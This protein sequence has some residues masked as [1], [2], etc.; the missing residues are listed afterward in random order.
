MNSRKAK[1][2]ATWIIVPLMALI[3][4][5]D[6]TTVALFNRYCKKITIEKEKFDYSNGDDRIHFL[7]T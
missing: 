7:N 2:I 3:F 1:K 5:L 4:I 6:I